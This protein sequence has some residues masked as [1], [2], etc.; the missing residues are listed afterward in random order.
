M[1]V[2]WRHKIDVIGRGPVKDVLERHKQ[3]GHVRPEHTRDVPES[4]NGRNRPGAT[5][6]DR[7]G[8]GATR[9]DP[10]RDRAR[11]PRTV[12]SCSRTDPVR[13]PQRVPYW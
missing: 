6:H 9:H 2:L 13:T 5:R 11:R 8:P 3:V 7:H 1:I 12:V 4:G 10:T